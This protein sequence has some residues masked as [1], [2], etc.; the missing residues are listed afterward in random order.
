MWSH[1]QRHASNL[2]AE[3]KTHLTI[4]ESYAAAMTLNIF[5]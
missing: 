5:K 4:W 3:L 2:V 1:R